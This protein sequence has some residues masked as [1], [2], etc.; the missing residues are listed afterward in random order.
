M[1]IR[2]SFH[3]ITKTN[4]CPT[5]GSSSSSSISL[6]KIFF[7]S[8][9]SLLSLFSMP[10]SPPIPATT[11]RYLDDSLEPCPFIC[12][13]PLGSSSPPVAPPLSCLGRFAP[14]SGCEKKNIV[15]NKNILHASLHNDNCIMIINNNDNS[16]M[17]QASR[18]NIKY[19]CISNCMSHNLTFHSWINN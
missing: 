10:P 18:N 15:K 5:S 6:S 13:T 14:L 2:H 16:C 7:L 4:S 12:L 1:K 11:S 19:I 3:T 17:Y 9:S 8:S